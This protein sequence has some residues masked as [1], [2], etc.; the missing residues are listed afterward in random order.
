MLGV[1]R[2][3]IGTDASVVAYLG[4]LVYYMMDRMEPT[5]RC[6]RPPG[7]IYPADGTRP[8]KRHPGAMPGTKPFDGS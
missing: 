3:T 1:V 7:D 2:E 6:L 4:D 8:E 5:D